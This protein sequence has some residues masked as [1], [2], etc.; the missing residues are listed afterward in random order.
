MDQLLRAGIRLAPGE[1]LGYLLCDAHATVKEDRVRPAQLLGP[2]DGYDSDEYLRLLLD[3]AEEVLL[4]F[5][6]D[7]AQL[8]EKIRPRDDSRLPKVQELDFARS[9]VS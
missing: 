4:F 3:A 9:A 6:Y 8:E 2:E 5:G 1:K 7:R